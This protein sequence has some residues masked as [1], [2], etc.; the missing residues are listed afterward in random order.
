M[1]WE[2]QTS[3][4]LAI[5]LHRL[6]RLFPWVQNGHLR[7]LQRYLVKKCWAEKTTSV[8]CEP[9]STWKTCCKLIW[10][11]ITASDGKHANKWVVINLTFDPP[12]NAAGVAK[13]ADNVSL[14]RVFPCPQIQISCCLL[15]LV[16]PPHLQHWSKQTGEAIRR[17]SQKISW[18]TLIQCDILYCLA[19]YCLAKLV[20]GVVLY[21]FH[22]SSEILQIRL[23]VSASKRF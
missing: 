20:C 2:W 22:F 19:T 21:L 17:I 11:E 23:A 15:A 10:R 3:L 5:V 1:S 13:C 14:I 18:W 4:W 8:N 7:T 12:V 16:L 6:R 9:A